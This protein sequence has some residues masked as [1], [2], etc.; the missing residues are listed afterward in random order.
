MR[1]RK[2]A[3]RA[4]LQLLHC[5]FGLANLPRHFFNA[6]LFHEPQHHHAPLF[7]WQT[8]HQP[9]Q[10]CPALHFFNFHAAG[11]ARI[12]SAPVRRSSV[13]GPA[14]PAVR[15]QIRG[16]PEQPRRKR[17]PPPLKPL[18]VGQR[19]MKYLR[20]QVL[21][22]SAVPHPPHNVGIHALEI[23]S[24]KARAKR[25]GSFCAASIRSRSSASFPGVLKSSFNE[26]SARS[27]VTQG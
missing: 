2:A 3:Q 8:I 20:G 23:D 18:Q 14:L 12:Q 26:F 17:N 6:F 9:K 21:G 19:M 27:S 25:A 4:E 7:L 13:R 5:A 1:A 16:N 10:R 11:R 24:R 22:F 15:N